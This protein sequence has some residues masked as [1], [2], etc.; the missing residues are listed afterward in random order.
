MAKEVKRSKGIVSVD[1]TNVSDSG[2]SFRVQPGDYAAKI[3]KVTPGVSKASGKPKLTFE[4]EGLNGAV[5]GRKIF[6][7]V[8]L[9]E[10]ALFKFRNL[11]LSLKV[12][13]KKSVMKIDITKL[14]GLVVGITV[15]DDEYKGKV[16]SAIIDTFPCTVKKDGKLI[17]ED[18]SDEDDSDDDVEDLDSMDDEDEDE[19]DDDDGD[20]E[21]EEEED[22]IPFDYSSM[23]EAELKK[24]C[25]EKGLK[26]Y[27]DLKK[28]ALIKKL[29]EFDAAE[30]EDED[31]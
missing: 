26:G 4:L 19:D 31:E 5:K 11:L 18:I 12:D 17:R 15:D 13:V 27:K 24:A 6:Y 29:E 16:K 22:D 20:E 9:Q 8:S 14:V 21:D 28:K 23:S 3:K 30:D 1:F 7:E 10:Q 2:G 25:K